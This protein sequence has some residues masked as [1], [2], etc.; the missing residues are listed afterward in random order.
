[1]SITK[2]FVIHGLHK[3]MGITGIFLSTFATLFVAGL[4]RQAAILCVIWVKP[5]KGIVA[6]MQAGGSGF[7]LPDQPG[8]LVEYARPFLQLFALTRRQRFAIMPQRNKPG[9]PG[10]YRPEEQ[11]GDHYER[12]V[13]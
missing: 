12:I 4:S 5:T 3:A 6:V 2:P 9:F 10:V 1:V 13:Q 11:D 8:V 7:S